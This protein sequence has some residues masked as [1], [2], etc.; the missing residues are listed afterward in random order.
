MGD[1]VMSLCVI[2]ELVKL[3]PNAS[4]TLLCGPLAYEVMRTIPCLERCVIV[5]KKPWKR[6]WLEIL[7]FVEQHRWDLVIDLKNTIVSR[8]TFSR[9]KLVFRPQTNQSSVHDDLAHMVG[10][11]KLPF[12]KLWIDEEAA[13]FAKRLLLGQDRI[14]T[15]GLGAARN[16]KIWPIQNYIALANL[17]IEHWSPDRPIKFMVVGS[18]DELELAEK[19]RQ[20]IPPSSLINLI[21]N[22]ET[23]SIMTQAACIA[24]SMLYVGNDSGFMHIAAAV[25]VPTVGIFGPTDSRVYGPFGPS[26]A[27]VTADGANAPVD[28]GAVPVEAVFQAARK[29]VEQRE[30][31]QDTSV[32]TASRWSP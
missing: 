4:I 13:E 21:A 30:L 18:R 8:L 26:A 7:W 31:D 14:V 27:A 32:A 24:H 28:I 1:G 10:T 19:L 12:P 6:H 16:N 3:Y 22:G 11:A 29:L 20:G 23:A 9:R 17:L 5:Y 15:F 25:E 2:Q